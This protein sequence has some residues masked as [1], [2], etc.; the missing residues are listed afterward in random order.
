VSQSSIV[1]GTFQVSYR[2]HDSVTGTF[3]NIS[4]II[5]SINQSINMAL[6]PLCQSQEVFKM[7]TR[8]NSV[9]K[10]LR[11]ARLDTES[12]KMTNLVFSL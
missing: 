7:N 9:L 3:S 12:E 4:F 6:M 11:A 2:S 1:S 5:Y 8:F 10:P